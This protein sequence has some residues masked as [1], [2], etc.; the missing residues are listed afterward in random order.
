[1]GT[2]LALC[3]AGVIVYKLTGH[4]IFLW[5][6]IMAMVLGFFSIWF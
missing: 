5:P 4:E 1:M 2:F 6:V 3:I